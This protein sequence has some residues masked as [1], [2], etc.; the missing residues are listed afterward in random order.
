M[1]RIKKHSKLNPVLWNYDNSLRSD[2]AEILTRIYISFMTVLSNYS[3]LSL[4]IEHDLMDVIFCGSAAE[5]FYDKNSDIDITLVIRADRYL[6]QMNPDIFDGFIKFIQVFFIEKY[7]PSVNG[8]PVDISIVASDSFNFTR[9]SLIQKKWLREPTKFSDDEIRK[10]EI[11]ADNIYCDIK[12]EIKLF[13]KNKANQEKITIFVHDLQKRRVDAWTDDIKDY[14]PFARAYSRI[15]HQGII[16]KMLKIDTD[17]IK[18][19]MMEK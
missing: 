15:S 16:K 17:N 19:L 3:G 9:Y 18:K 4:D 13:L 11:Q 1:I 8:I 2:V 7:A 10:M 14:I 6:K 12:K 5:Y